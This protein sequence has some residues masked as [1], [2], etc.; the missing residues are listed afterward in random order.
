MGHW[1]GELYGFRGQRF[2]VDLLSPYEML[3]HWSMVHIDIPTNNARESRAAWT[4]LGQ[5]RN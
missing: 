4:Q 1:P 5:V 2:N 3:L